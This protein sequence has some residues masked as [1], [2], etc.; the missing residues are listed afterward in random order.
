MD[1]LE[2]IDC[3]Q[4]SRLLVL[5]ASSSHMWIFQQFY[6]HTCRCQTQKDYRD[7]LRFEYVFNISA[8]ITSADNTALH[9]AESKQQVSLTMFVS[10]NTFL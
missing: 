10:D 4:L 7:V 8:T 5:D 3:L 9:N 6:F 2:N 1:L